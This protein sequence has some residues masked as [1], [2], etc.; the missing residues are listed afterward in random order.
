[1]IFIAVFLGLLAWCI[2]DGYFNETFAEKYTDENGNPTGWLVVNQKAPPY[3]LGAAVLTAAYYSFVIRNKKITA[4]EEGL[5]LNSKK[6]IAYDSIEKIDKTFFNKKGY[7]TITYKNENGE[8]AD[9]KIS[10]DNYDNLPPILE[11][12]VEKIS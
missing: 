6:K 11:R 12:L 2:Y 1:M 4:D 9:L 8:Q 10:D 5:V 7:F 3:L